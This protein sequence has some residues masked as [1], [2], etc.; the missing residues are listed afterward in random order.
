[1]SEFAE[2]NA[3]PA[4]NSLWPKRLRW[5]FAELIVVVAGILL[6]LGLQSWWQGRDN[7]ARGA[8]YQQQIL[9]DARLTRNTYQK[10]LAADYK[11]RT[12]TL[13]LSEALHQNTDS[14]QAEQAMQWLS[15]ASGWFYDPRPIFGNINSLI[16]TGEIQRI[17]NPQIRAS[18][19]EHA[20]IINGALA[21]ADGQPDRMRRAN[22][23]ELLRLEEA[24]LP[25]QHGEVDEE[26]NN[27][28]ADVKT[29][30]PLYLAAWPKLRSDAQYRNDQNMRIMAY[31]NMTMYNKEILAATEWLIGIL[32]ADNPK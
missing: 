10:A 25:P 20:S 8:L 3:S 21:D 18:I 23:N 7:D 1:M 29:F 30:L 24:G 22:D 16:N 2:T 27:Q 6:A 12:A 19:I 5:F 9:A 31:D 15:V 28:P 32:E 17:Q 11:L 4:K 14:L 13:H 26:G